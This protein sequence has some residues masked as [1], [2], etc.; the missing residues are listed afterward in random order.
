MRLSLT[1]DT[2]LSKL[3]RMCILGKFQPNFTD[4]SLSENV[5]DKLIMHADINDNTPY[6]NRN[7]AA[8]VAEAQA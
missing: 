4:R 2:L 3:L 1:F 5:T 6:A 8:P 7:A